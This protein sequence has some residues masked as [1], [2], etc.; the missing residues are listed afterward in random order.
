MKI[1][2]FNIEAELCKR[3]YY[4]FVKYMWN[5]IESCDFEDNWHI[6]CICDHLQAVEEGKIKRILISI[7]PRNSKSLLANIFFSAWYFLRQPKKSNINVSYGNTL[8]VAQGQL[9]RELINSE[10]F[11]KVW[12][13]HYPDIKVS[14]QE[15]SKSV[16]GNS[17]GGKTQRTSVTS[18]LTGLGST[19]Y[20]VCDDILNAA[21][22]TSKAK[23]EELR[24]FWEKAIFSRFSDQIQG[25]MIVIAQRL[26]ELDNIGLILENTEISKTYDKIII[27]M[28]YTGENQIESSIGWKDPRTEVGELLNPSRFPLEVV[29]DIKNTLGNLNY[30][31]QYQQKPISDAGSIFKRES[32]T[33]VKDINNN[34]IVKTIIAYDLAVATTKTADFTAG[35]VMNLMKNGTYIISEIIQEKVSTDAR[36]ELIKQTAIRYGHKV[37]TYV[38]IQPGVGKSLLVYTQ[39]NCAPYIVKGVKPLGNKE[40]RCE[41]LAIGFESGNV[42]ILVADWNHKFIQELIG[43]PNAAHDDMVDAS[44]YAYNNLALTQKSSAGVW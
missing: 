24:A 25:R 7:P 43:F 6:K 12:K 20:I 18:A 37:E 13:F 17:Y 29:E 5:T 11:Q 42:K 38:E 26:H 44:A 16:L 15:N 1:S 36:E 27:P 34:D 23:L 19:S 14:S 8:S 31:Q 21:Q 22:S 2:K 32:L 41:S 40:S 3:S 4:Y 9:S 28:E 35:C 33:F 39:K 10:T 30:S